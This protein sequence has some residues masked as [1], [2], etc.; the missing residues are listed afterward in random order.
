MDRA[1]VSG[2]MMKD[3]SGVEYAVEHMPANGLC[4]FSSIAHCI[5]GNKYGYMDIIEDSFKA[6]ERNPALFVQ[7]TQYGRQ[8][9]N[10]SH[11]MNHMRVAVSN[12]GRQSVHSSFWLEDAHLVAFSA[13]YAI[14]IFVYNSCLKTWFVYGNHG[15][16]GSICLHFNGSHFDV[17][18]GFESG[19]VVRPPIPRH[20]V[21]QGMHSE[22]SSWTA[23]DID[24][25][26]FSYSG[27]WKW[28]ENE[29]QISYPAEARDHL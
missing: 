16:N 19:T 21:P 2:W 26:R 20:A 10:L 3:H 14:T 13:M 7:R 8:N 5:H 29:S 25:N 6:F 1:L 17:L 23:V 15:S 27:V 4:G 24:C 18:N 9:H 11:Y 28:P 12:V 22:C